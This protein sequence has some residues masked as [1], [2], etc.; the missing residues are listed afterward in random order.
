[1]IAH[2]DDLFV[3]WSIEHGAWWRPGRWGYCETLRGAGRFSRREAKQ[4]IEGANIVAFHECMIPVAALDRTGGVEFHVPITS[5]V[6]RELRVVVADGAGHEC[7]EWERDGRCLLCDRALMDIVAMRAAAR[8]E[9][10]VGT[11]AI[12]TRTT[13]VCDVGE[14]GVCYDVYELLDAPVR[15]NASTR[16]GYSFIFQ[17][18]RYDGFS[19]DDV[20]LALTLTGEVCAD[21]ADYEFTNVVQLARDF[22]AGVFDAALRRVV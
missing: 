21:V 3:I 17:S 14:R 1:M 18:G 4:I 13:G 10:A 5:T 11:I 22:E 20:R 15:D 8:G 19:P 12:A 6:L 2:D 16:P 7:A 9:P